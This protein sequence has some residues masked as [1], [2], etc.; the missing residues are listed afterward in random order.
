MKNTTKLT[1]EQKLECLSLAI[2][3]QQMQDGGGTHIVAPEK[4]IEAA[5]KYADFIASDTL[6]TNQ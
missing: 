5:T 4:V 2:K 1:P 6:Q 3:S